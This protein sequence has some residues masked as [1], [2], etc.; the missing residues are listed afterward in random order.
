MR[1]FLVQRLLFQWLA[2]FPGVPPQ[3]CPKV[4]SLLYGKLE[5]VDLQN[6]EEP[7][8]LRLWTLKS[9]FGQLSIL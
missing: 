1:I 3:K 8:K 9:E 6:L 4:A 7:Q 5:F 2:D